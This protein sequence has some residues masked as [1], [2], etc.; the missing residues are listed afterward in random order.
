MSNFSISPLQ[1]PA[2]PCAQNPGKWFNLDDNLTGIIEHRASRKRK[3]EAVEPMVRQFCDHCPL[4]T[5]EDC[6]NKALIPDGRAK[7]T[8]FTGVAGGELFHEGEIVDILTDRR[9]RVLRSA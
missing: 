6:L 3:I 9:K 1:L 4:A 7:R 5:K 8:S 2:A